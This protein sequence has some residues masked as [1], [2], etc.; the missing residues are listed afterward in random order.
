MFAC[1]FLATSFVCISFIICCLYRI[2]FKVLKKILYLSKGR[3]SLRRTSTTTER[4]PYNGQKKKQ[5]SVC[6]C[7]VGVGVGGGGLK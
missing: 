7:V 5:R 2:S 4:A 1:I 6:V 3:L